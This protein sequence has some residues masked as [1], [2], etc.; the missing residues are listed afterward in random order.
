M[1][2]KTD[3]KR[4]TNTNAEAPELSAALEHSLLQKSFEEAELLMCQGTKEKRE[5][6]HLLFLSLANQGHVQSQTKLGMTFSQGL[7]TLPNEVAAF[8]WYTKAA[9]NG[10]PEA[11]SNL[12]CYY[13]YGKTTTRDLNAAFTWFQRSAEKEWSPGKYNLAILY[14]EGEAVPKNPARALALYQSILKTEKTT[15]ITPIPGAHFRIGRFYEQGLGGV[16]KNLLTAINHYTKV[17]HNRPDASHQAGLCY[18]ELAAEKGISPEKRKEYHKKM[19]GY[20]KLASLAPEFIHAKTKM[21]LCFLRGTGTLQNIPEALKLL[22]AQAELKHPEACF[23]LA[24]LYAHPKGLSDTKHTWLKQ[25]TKQAFELFKIASENDASLTDAKLQLAPCY[26]NGLGTER[27]THKGVQLL[28]ELQATNLSARAL[29]GEY[30]LNGTEGARDEKTGVDLLESTIKEGGVIAIPVLIDYLSTRDPKKENKRILE[31]CRQGALQNNRHCLYRLGLFYLNGEYVERN[32]EQACGWFQK[33]MHEG[34]EEASALLLDIAYDYLTDHN[35]PENEKRAFDLFSQLSNAKCE[36]AM[37]GLHY[38]S[39]KGIGKKTNK[40]NQ[41]KSLKQLLAL[42]KQGSGR[43]QVLLGQHYFN[44]PLAEDKKRAFEC[45]QNAALKQEQNAYP[46]LGLCYHSGIGTTQDH[47]LALQNFNAAAK[48]KKTA[49]YYY[50]G[51][52]AENGI[53]GKKSEKEA[54]LYYVK[55]AEHHCVKSHYALGQQYL[56]T[57]ETKLAFEHLTKAAEAEHE[58]AISTLVKYYAEGANVFKNETEAVCL[59]KKAAGLKITEAEYLLAN[60]YAQGKG[61]PK[62][63][64]QAFKYYESAAVK[65]HVNAQYQLGLCYLNARGT[66]KNRAQGM[67]WLEKAATN[68]LVEAHYALGKCFEEKSSN[69]KPNL[70]KAIE[71]YAASASKGHALAKEALTRCQKQQEDKTRGKLAYEKAKEEETQKLAQ[72]KKEAEVKPLTIIVEPE[73]SPDIPIIVELSHVN[74]TEQPTE[75]LETTDSIPADTVSDPLV[76]QQNVP[77]NSP[78]PYF[79]PSPPYAPYYNHYNYPPA[80]IMAIPIAPVY[81]S[82]PPFQAWF[83]PM[84]QP[85]YLP[86]LQAPTYV[87]APPIESF[88]PPTPFQPYY[89]LQQQRYTSSTIASGNMQTDPYTG[90]APS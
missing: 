88:V 37:F 18:E 72:I 12:G 60:H 87:V 28:T 55:G 75:T 34:H 19:F 73:V 8:A 23:Y 31:L 4:D 42:E 24:N 20:F 57:Q 1:S 84:Q 39:L 69:K 58:E 32:T 11:M 80:P 47:A 67:L 38:C 90:F 77:Q 27:N 2:D 89:A 61:V 6:A 74:D 86:Y 41:E 51:W 71:H 43:A 79:E 13:K 16:S 30:H 14:E 50:L 45:F 15:G 48:A 64:N 44:S 65:K 52:Y 70:A 85:L 21:A 25:D 59:L 46:F 17:A 83:I 7:G 36:A 53:D 5:K 3:K 54:R 33:A 78:P 22:K 35:T 56:K 63:Y 81:S 29:L 76:P 9:H 68:G 49:S 40:Q 26:L 10:D 66:Q 82:T 62:E